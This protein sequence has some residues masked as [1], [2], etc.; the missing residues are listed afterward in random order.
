MP[1]TSAINPPLRIQSQQRLARVKV[2]LVGYG[3]WGP[4]LARNF[5]EILEAELGA[6]CD[7]RQDS[8]KHIY[9]LYP[10]TRITRKFQDLLKSD[11]DAIAIATPV[12]THYQLARAALEA[13]KHVLIE[14]PIAASSQ[15]AQKLIELAHRQNLV[16]MVGHTFE[17][18]PAVEAIKS[19]IESGD[20]GEI[21]YIDSIRGNFGIF[22]SDINVIWDLATHDLSIFHY[23][24]NQ[25]P[26]SIS[27]HGKTCVQPHKG[28]HDVASLTLHLTGDTLVTLRVSWLEPVKVR[29]LTIIGSRKMLLYDDTA[30][31]KIVVYHQGMSNHGFDLITSDVSGSDLQAE[32][33]IYPLKWLEPLQA[34]TQHFID[35]IEPI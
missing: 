7:L 31:H 10:D 27:A 25:E 5:H 30:E 17:Y 14:K 21:H 1:A 2:G 24:L 20:L 18:H 13:G 4:K 32:T 6:I 34:E 12:N 22:R 8:L 11:L 28:L 35:C 16:L 23:I 19:I 33:T 26:L 15:E 3:Y 29:R 9:R